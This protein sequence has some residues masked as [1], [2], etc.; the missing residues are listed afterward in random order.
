MSN[1]FVFTLNIRKDLH[2]DSNMLLFRKQHVITKSALS[3]IVYWEE[4]EDIKMLIR[5]RYITKN[6]TMEIPS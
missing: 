5:S 1:A 2:G 3:Q 4:F 6:V